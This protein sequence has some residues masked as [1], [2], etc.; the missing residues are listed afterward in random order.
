M[1]FIIATSI[2]FTNTFTHSSKHIFKQSH[3]NELT[4]SNIDSH[5]HELTHLHIQTNSFS[6]AKIRFLF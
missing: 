5:I 6:G 1:S 2:Y 3:I 4:H